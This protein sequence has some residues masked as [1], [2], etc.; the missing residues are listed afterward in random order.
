MTNLEWI[1]Q[2]NAGE[3]AEFLDGFIRCRCCNNDKDYFREDCA[4]GIW[5]WLQTERDNE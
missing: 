1:Q 3:L 2:M 4:S 5:V